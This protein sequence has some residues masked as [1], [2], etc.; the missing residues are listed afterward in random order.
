MLGASL[1]A[2]IR[3]R[4][5]LGTTIALLFGQQALAVESDFAGK[6]LTIIITS[7]P[8]GGTDNMARL[9]GRYMQKYL[10]GK[11]AIIFQNIPGAGGIKA[12]NFFVQQ[13]K[14]DGLTSVIGSGSNLNPTVTRTAAVQYDTKKLMMYG[15]FPA[16]SGVLMLRK[17][18]AD[19]FYDKSKPAV[20]MGGEHNLRAADQVAVWG[21]VYLGWNV[22]WVMGYA[23]S[24]DIILAAMRG[25][26]ELAETYERSLIGRLQRTGDFTFPVQIGDPKDGKFS[27]SPSFPEVVVFSDLIKPKL[28]TEQEIKA[29]EAWETLVQAGKWAALPPNTRPEIL[30]VYRQAFDQMVKDPQFI[31]EAPAILGEGFTTISGDDMQRVAI[32]SDSISDESM[33]FIDSLRER[34]GIRLEPKK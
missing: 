34:V 18:A 11:P 29:F 6:T 1:R 8:G 24:N 20:I 10:P 7:N 19:R 4:V 27:R 9:V 32:R 5:L 31:A 12:L 23:G 22:R 14:P 21:P 26:V 2:G 13:V 3:R 15:G 17:D 33:K 28:K 25:E 30:D 16:P